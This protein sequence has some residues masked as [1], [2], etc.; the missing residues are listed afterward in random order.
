[1]RTEWILRTLIMYVLMFAI[2]MAIGGLVGSCF[3]G[4]NSSAWLIGTTICFGI[5][6]LICFIS[7]FFSK[8]IT[9]KAN[10]VRIITEMDNPRFYSIVKEVAGKAGVPMPEVGIMYSDQPNAFATGRNP[11][12]AAVVATTSLLEL[13]PDD[14]LR[15]VIAHEMSHVKNRDILIM[16]I[17][18]AVSATICY[19][20]NIGTWLMVITADRGAERAAAFVLGLVLRIVVPIAALLIQLGI[21]RSR[22]YLADETGAM[23][24]NDPRALARALDRLENGII[25][26]NEHPQTYTDERG[27]TTTAFSPADNQNTAHMWIANPFAGK[28]SVISKLFSTHPPMEDRIRKL[29]ELADEMHL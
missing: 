29:N 18:S 13:L 4:I 20:T 5:S 7:Y 15:G 21:S 2:L 8:Q 28:K 19:I 11:S 1:M 10:H 3:N 24:I 23:I 9:L 26:S 27:S 17:A 6:L 25:F 14:E 22:E 12:N 16:S